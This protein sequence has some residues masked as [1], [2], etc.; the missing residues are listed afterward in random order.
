MNITQERH[1]LLKLWLESFK[2]VNRCAGKL[3]GILLISLVLWAMVIGVLML[4]MGKNSL[5]IM[6]A[7]Q[8]FGIGYFMAYVALSLA[9]GIYSL[10]VYTVF[11]RLIANQALGEP[12]SLADTFSSS[13]L[14]TLYQIVFGIIIAI[15]FYLVIWVVAAISQ[16]ISPTLMLVLVPVFLLVF[17]FA[18]GIRLFYGPL[19]IAVTGK[20]PVEGLVHSWKMT[21]GGT[22]YLDTLLVVLISFISAILV[23]LFVLGIPYGAK[24]I[25]PLYFANGFNLAHPSLAWIIVGLLAVL[26]IGIL[27]AFAY[28]VIMAFPV[29]VFTNR[30]ALLFDARGNSPFVTLPEFELPTMHPNPDHMQQAE[31]TLR[32]PILTDEDLKQAQESVPAPVEEKSDTPTSADKPQAQ[33]MASLEGIGVSKSSINTSEKDTESLSKHLDKVYTPK[34]EDFVQY[35]EE[36]RMPTI[37][38][39]DDM[40]KQLEENQAQYAPKPK[41]NTEKDDGPDSIKMSKF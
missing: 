6:M 25:I 30:N 11:V 14:P 17:F 37:L 21:A 9:M 31:S 39:D 40:A 23:E 1:S 41:E 5:F 36:D 10:L 26:V 15:P 24:I 13:V 29:L 27:T 32:T 38:F 12:Q 20:G 4:V 3:I 28:V 16:R 35:Q 7:P 33:G 34:K 22:N 19:A 18:V 8:M 2:V